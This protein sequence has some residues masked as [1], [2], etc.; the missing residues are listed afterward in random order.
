MERRIK[1]FYEFGA[2]RLDATDR[3]LTRNGLPLQLTPKAIETLIT[4][5][6][7]NGYIVEK[8]KLLST[9]WADSFVEEGVLS[10][11]IFS[12]RKALGEDGKKGQLI[13]TIPRRGYRFNAEVREVWEELSEQSTKAQAITNTAK[14]T[15]AVLPF[16]PLST[17]E[18]DQYLGLG[19][20]DALIT[21]LSNIKQLI[22]RPTSSIRKYV[23]ALQS[24]TAIAKELSVDSVLEGSIRRAGERIRITVQLVSAEDGSPL[25][26]ENFDERFTDIFTV[27][28]SVSAQVA[29]ALM[30]QL[31]GEEK[32]HLTKRYTEN[33]EA[34]MLY[35][36]G[37]YFWNMR[38]QEDLKR[39][40]EYFHQAIEIDPLYA[41]AYSGLA[42]SYLL[43][44]NYASPRDAMPKAKA[45]AIKAIEIDDML[46]E[47]RASL[48]RIRMTFDWD[49]SN[50]EKEFQRA[51]ELNP[52]Y[53]TAHQWY[54][55][56]L[57]AVGRT[58]EAKAVII[59]A[60]ELEP[61]SLI[62]NSAVGWV[63]Y[64]AREY[65]NAITQYKRVLEMKPDFV[66]ALREVGVV[67]EQ[68]GM[69]EEALASM[70]K[71][72]S[73]GGENALIVGL[74]G[75]VYAV[76]GNRAK[77]RSVLAELIEMSKRTYVVPQILASIYVALGEC[78]QAIKW[79]EK[80]CVDHSSPLVWLKIDP[81][82]DGIRSDLRFKNLLKRI[83][84]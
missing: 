74:L 34:Y 69:Y 33:T 8:E 5:V 42:D 4:L 12:L 21:R 77:A 13:E 3:V 72:I 57:L 19:M 60:L 32:R 31:S 43:G 54:A 39:G 82:F 35:L 23:K 29:R 25:W 79:L 59:R 50:A 37:R 47:A 18:G 48:A 76:S 71:A 26:A 65:D 17:D 7:N 46:A 81:P 83:G 78:D 63:Y 15:I 40:I 58:S 52:N 24:T 68:K 55:N 80:A 41:L 61:M 53:A 30:L 66:M 10:V 16:E 38:T 67:Y 6:E 75:H 28:D 14:K 56:L 45:A 44:N 11:N 20:A 62:I 73:V 70:Q 51:I 64:L 2:F 1:H 27:E 84:F 36:K 22:V 49:W 9:V